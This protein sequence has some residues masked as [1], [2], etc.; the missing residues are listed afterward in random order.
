M[1]LWEIIDHIWTNQLHGPLHA[2]GY[3]LNPMLHYA[4]GFNV[5]YEVRKG[6][7]DCL[8]RLV[9]GDITMMNKIDV[10]CDSFENK[11]GLF[12]SALAI[13][14][15]QNKTPANWW[16]SYGGQYPELQ[17]FAIRVLSLTCSSS[18]CERNRR[19]FERVRFHIHDEMYFMLQIL[20]EVSL[21]MFVFI[22]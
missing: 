9:G 11:L 18:S 16:N 7:Y 13:A 2:A 19:A 5:D 21:F 1:P 22:L 10:Q 12:G 15:L 20:Y 4:E 3:Y 8:G 17:K 14:G 6:L